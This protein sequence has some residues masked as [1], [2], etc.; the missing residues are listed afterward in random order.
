ME[1]RTPSNHRTPSGRITIRAWRRCQ[2]TPTPV[3]MTSRITKYE[4]R[5]VRTERS[6]ESTTRW[7]HRLRNDK[8]RLGTPPLGRQRAPSLGGRWLGWGR[9]TGRC[10]ST[11]SIQS[12]DQLSPSSSTNFAVSESL[13][14]P[15]TSA[16]TFDSRC[17]MFDVP[18]RTVLIGS[19][20]AANL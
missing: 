19:W 12:G 20:Y 18:V 1:S 13:N 9:T 15:R 11:P 6:L 16:A 17:K 10:Q 3:V 5:E 14:G 2:S 4:R 8:Y 7:A